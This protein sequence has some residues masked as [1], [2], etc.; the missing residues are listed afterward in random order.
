MNE[1]EQGVFQVEVNALVFLRPTTNVDLENPHQ[2][3]IYNDPVHHDLLIS[4][5]Q[6]SEQCN[7]QISEIIATSPKIGSIM[8]MLDDKINLLGDL[9]GTPEQ[10]K[11]LDKQTVIISDTKIAF[12][13]KEKL[14]IGSTM[15]LKL[16]LF[17]QY[18]SITAIVRLIKSHT[19]ED[20][21]SKLNEYANWNVFD[22]EFITANDQQFLS[23]YILQVQAQ[24]IKQKREL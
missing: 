3:N 19:N 23:R 5:K 18:N 13:S 16:T 17:P 10:Y 2:I 6:I 9:L 20:H 14:A 21:V 4:L 22:F 7:K 12:G 15:C 1:G 8:T 11:L 24:E